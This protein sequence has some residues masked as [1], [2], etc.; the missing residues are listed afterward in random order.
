MQTN[1]EKTTLKNDVAAAPTLHQK[2]SGRSFD[3]QKLRKFRKA[4]RL[5][6]ADAALRLGIHRTYFVAIEAGKRVPSRRVQNAIAEFI[7]KAERQPP[8]TLWQEIHRRSSPPPPTFDPSVP[9]VP[10]ISWASA[11]QVVSFEN[12]VHQTEEKI[13]TDC[14]DPTAFA[15]IIEG[16]SM[17]PKFF[18]GD[19]VVF[20][21]NSE[22]RNGDVVFAKLNDGR[23][24]FKYFHTSGPEGIRVKLVSENPN[25]S[26]IEVDRSELTFIFPALE[27][28]RRLRQ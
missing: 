7:E 16:E 26:P 18:A 6:Q 19:R 24:L 2:P 21:P 10:V 4:L 20:V 11:A 5:N 9:L 28:K 15:I 17:E 25:Y 14:K 8:N 13:E 12:L 23:V 1:I 22:I 27:V 3:I